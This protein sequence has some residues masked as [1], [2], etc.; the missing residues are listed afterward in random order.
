MM[1]PRQPSSVPAHWMPRLLNICRVYSGKQPPITDRIMVLAAK[2]DAARD[3]FFFF[4][5]FFFLVSQRIIEASGPA[6][7][8][9]R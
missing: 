3:F 9:F 6:T 1:A 4:F 2:A 5:F 7:Y 8:K